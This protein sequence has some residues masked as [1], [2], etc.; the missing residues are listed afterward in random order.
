MPTVENKKVKHGI[1]ILT[2]LEAVQ[3]PKSG[4]D[5]LQEVTKR[6]MQRL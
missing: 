2:L 5:S 6:G 4:S 3:L 1:S